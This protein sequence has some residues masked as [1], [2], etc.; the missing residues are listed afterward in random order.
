MLHGL[1]QQGNLVW[2]RGD[3]NFPYSRVFSS[4]FAKSD[5]E[6]KG[7]YTFTSGDFSYGNRP[8]AS[9]HILVSY[10]FLDDGE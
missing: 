7:N 2:I 8:M 9:R 10:P 3:G 5:G 6:E 1:N 4:Q